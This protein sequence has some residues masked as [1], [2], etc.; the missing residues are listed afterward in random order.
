VSEQDWADRFSYQVDNFLNDA[1][2]TDAKPLPAEYR[3]ALDLARTLA[4]ADFSA[5]SRVRLDLRR[6]LLDQFDGLEGQQRR[7]GYA[8]RRFWQHHPVM[9]LGVVILV[10]FL[11]A[12]LV[13]PVAAQGGIDDLMRRLIPRQSP[14]GTL[15]V[16]VHPDSQTETYRGPV[17][18]TLQVVNPIWAI[19]TAGASLPQTPIVERRGDYWVIWTAIGGFADVLPDRYAAVRHFDTYDVA[20]AAAP[21]AL[22]QPGHLPAGYAFREAML[23]P[24]EWFFLF[25]GGPDGD[26]ILAQRPA[27]QGERPNGE[28]GHFSVEVRTDKPIETVTLNGQPAGWIDG[29]GLIWETESISYILGGANLSLDKA[30]R[31]AESL[32]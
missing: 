24:P 23:A 26:I 21:F 15:T 25:Y 4:A 14:P 17:K 5:E 18:M 1:G 28:T 19:P 29:Y 12:T 13:W 22:R 31:I 2:R 6:R 16:T 3:Q 30:T 8:L 9:T 11:V 10:A 7:R 20:Q 32:E 27:F